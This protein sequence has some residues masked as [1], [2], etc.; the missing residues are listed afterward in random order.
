MTGTSLPL[1]ACS[2]LH[3]D[4][5]IVECMMQTM[6]DSEQWCGGGLRWKEGAGSLLVRRGAGSPT[7]PLVWNKLLVSKEVECLPFP[8]SAIVSTQS[9]RCCEQTTSMMSSVTVFEGRHVTPSVRYCLTHLNKSRE[10][11]LLDAECCRVGGRRGRQRCKSSW[12]GVKRTGCYATRLV[13]STA[14]QENEESRWC[15]G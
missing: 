4:V 10:Q 14:M 9:K 7:V 11:E 15:C 1:H 5:W 12:K 13:L 2:I 6:D 8:E 3:D